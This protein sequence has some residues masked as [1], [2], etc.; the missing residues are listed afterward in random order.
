MEPYLPSLVVLVLAGVSAA[1]DPRK[2]RTGVYLLTGLLLAA[3]TAVGSTLEVV[4]S[5]I[6]DSTTEAWILLGG[7]LVVGVSVIVLGVMLLLN[8][9]TVVRREGRSPAHLLSLLLGLGILGYIGLG[10]SAVFA[11]SVHLVG[12]LFLLAL[13]I[14]WCGYGL[15]AYLLWSWIYG[16]ATS[17]FGRAVD[18]VIVLG[19]GVVGGEVWPLLAARLERGVQWVARSSDKGRS[20]VLVLSGGQGPDEPLPEAEA[21]A[22]WVRDHGG[23]TDVL[24]EEASTTTRENLVFSAALLAE[25]GPVTRVAVVTSSFHAFRAALLMRSI[26]L[27]GYTVGAR[28]ARYYWPSAM[29]REYVAVMR[30]NLWLTVIG[31]GTSIVPLVGAVLAGAFF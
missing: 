24:L 5:L 16:L 3:L 6:P 23:P 30:D 14:G 10:V 31:V 11:N 21:M 13:P 25:R 28:T 8:G 26:G 4:G 15:V 2:V 7:L 17:R 19:A 27:S 20:P 18:T 22:R 12:F 9:L 1:L 29:L